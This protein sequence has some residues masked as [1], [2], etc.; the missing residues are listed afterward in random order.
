MNPARTLLIVPPFASI[1]RA[2]IGVHVLQSVAR[3]QGLQVDVLY[4]NLIFAAQLG[5]LE[6]EA[7][8]EHWFM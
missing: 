3:Q 8:C 5:E 1:H 2:A 4:S 6:H 7:I